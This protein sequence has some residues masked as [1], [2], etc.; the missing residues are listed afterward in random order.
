MKCPQCGHGKSR[1][2]HTFS[3]D[4]ITWRDRLCTRCGH[5]WWTSESED[6]PLDHMRSEIQIHAD[7]LQTPS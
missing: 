7:P 1:I 3:T 4:S 2:M 6:E 5:H